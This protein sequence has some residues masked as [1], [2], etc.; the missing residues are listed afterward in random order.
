MSMGL[1]ETSTQ[2]SL[3]LNFDQVLPAVTSIHI[4][5]VNG[6]PILTFIPEKEF[7]SVV[8]SSP[9]LESGVEYTMSV[10]GETTGKIVDGLANPA[11]Y[12]AGSQYTSFAVNSILT[13]IGNTYGHGLGGGPR[14]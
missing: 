14:P 3:L 5:D 8:F 6:N 1:S 13:S 12:S 9:Q 11:D 10:G 4:E 2:N 7:Q